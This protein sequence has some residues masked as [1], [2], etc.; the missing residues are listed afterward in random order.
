MH[1]DLIVIGGGA[2]SEKGFFDLMEKVGFKNIEVISKVRNARTGHPL[3]ICANV[4]A[5]I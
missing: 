1:Y 2:M 5:Q 3:A 4:R